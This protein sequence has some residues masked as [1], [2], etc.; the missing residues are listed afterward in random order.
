MFKIR[1]R[2][3]AG[4]VIEHADGRLASPFIYLD[5]WDA[6]D[7]LRAISP[8]EADVYEILFGAF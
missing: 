4:W 8:E 3:G 5:R 1:Q 6:L 7:D 2:D